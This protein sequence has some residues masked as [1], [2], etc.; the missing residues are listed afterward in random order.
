MAELTKQNDQS[1]EAFLN[2]VGKQYGWFWQ[3]SL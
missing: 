2:E 3:L 1:V